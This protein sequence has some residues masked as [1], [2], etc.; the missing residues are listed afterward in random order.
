M[1]SRPVRVGATAG[2]RVER[3]PSSPADSP[4]LT[5]DRP[6]DRAQHQR[7][8]AQQDHQPDGATGQ[9]LSVTWTVR[10]TGER[11][12]ELGGVGFPLPFNNYWK[13]LKRAEAEE[14][15]VLAEPFIGGAHGY[16]KVA[17]LS[18]GTAPQPRL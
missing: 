6:D 7:D 17:R 15:A 9:G 11:T 10:N 5:D 2:D 14:R 3:C 12:L 16:V 1:R 8:V 4:P 13:D 18:G